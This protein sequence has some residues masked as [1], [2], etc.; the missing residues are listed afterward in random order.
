MPIAIYW[1][2]APPFGDI[3]QGP[4]PWDSLHDVLRLDD[5]QVRYNSQLL[6]MN[7]AVLKYQ[8]NFAGRSNPVVSQA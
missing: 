8:H 6:L 7:S 5:D 2:E 1:K 4:Y 3:A